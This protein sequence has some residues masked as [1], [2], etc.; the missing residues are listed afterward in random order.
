MFPGTRLLRAPVW[1]PSGG[2]GTREV[3]STVAETLVALYRVGT[4]ETRRGRRAAR[5]PTSQGNAES[6]CAR[7][8][9]ANREVS[10]READLTTVCFLP[11]RAD[12]ERRTG[13]IR[14][15][16]SGMHRALDGWVLACAPASPAQTMCHHGPLYDAWS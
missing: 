10:E 7:I 2:D 5:S 12:K 8:K 9:S 1:C 4:I 15:A 13:K 3:G 11:T 6:L 14:G 16:F